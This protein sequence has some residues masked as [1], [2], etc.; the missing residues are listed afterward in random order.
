LFFGGDRERVVLIPGN[1]DISHRPVLRATQLTALPAE[2]EQRAI[3][4]RQLREEDSVW[5]WVGPEFALR[6]T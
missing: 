2:P 1:H 3:V 4:A 5:R 6:R